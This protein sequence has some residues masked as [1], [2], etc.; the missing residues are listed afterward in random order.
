M[1]TIVLGATD[2]YVRIFDCSLIGAEQSPEEAEEGAPEVI[3]VHGGHVAG[4]TEID[5]NPI[6]DKFPWVGALHRPKLLLRLV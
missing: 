4:I 6:E 1:T 5:W 3:F 2:R